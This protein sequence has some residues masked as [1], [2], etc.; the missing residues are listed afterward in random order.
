MRGPLYRICWWSLQVTNR[1]WFQV[2]VEGRHH[3]PATGGV[4]LASNHQSFA[5]PLLLGA[6]IWR[7]INFLARDTLFSHRV[8]GAALRQVGAVPVKRGKA[9]RES[10]HKVVELA[11]A[12]RV[13]CVFPE[14]TRS[15]D[16]R[17]SPL[18]KGILLMARMAGVPVVPVGISGMHRLWPKDRKFPRPGP[19]RIAYGAPIPAADFERPETLEYLSD[20]LSLLARA[21][22]RKERLPDPDAEDPAS[23]VASSS[24]FVPAP[25]DTGVRRSPSQQSFFS[26]GGASS[27]PSK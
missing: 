27:V 4:I 18:K 17:L 26:S 25:V 23:R 24:S 16:G 7:R 1:T 21:A 9:D 22:R 13:V 20:A 6:S 2:K 11:R 3:V 12:G 19:V 8:F 10:L 5:D 14:G 15:L